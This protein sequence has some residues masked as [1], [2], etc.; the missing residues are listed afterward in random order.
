MASS[1]AKGVAV[2]AQASGGRSSDGD[3]ILA[4]IRGSAINQD[5][6]APAETVPNANA[7]AAVVRAALDAAGW[8]S[9]TSLCRGPRDRGAPGRSGRAVVAGRS[10]PPAEET[11]AGGIG[12]GQ[13]GAPRCRRRHG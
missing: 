1:A 12:Q 8:R 2:A 6:E 10:L 4:V 13:H 3:A 7:Q 11:S 9:T 5:G